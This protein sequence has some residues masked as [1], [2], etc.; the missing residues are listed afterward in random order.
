M[1]ISLNEQKFIREKWLYSYLA[2]IVMTCITLIIKVFQSPTDFFYYTRTVT[3][4]DQ[5]PQITHLPVPLTSI[6]MQLCFGACFYVGL[7]YLSYR[8]VYQKRA[9]W[10]LLVII[11]GNGYFTGINLQQAI[12]FMYSMM[13]QFYDVTIYG[14]GL[15]MLW[16]IYYILTVAVGVCMISTSSKLYF[17]HEMLERDDAE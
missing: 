9:T 3:I 8:A 7:W 5:P 13:A 4:G 17:I 10:W 14:L 6:A 1:N 11:A 2:T 15:N 16:L 12:G